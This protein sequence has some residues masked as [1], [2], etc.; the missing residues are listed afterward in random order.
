MTSHLREPVIG[1]GALHWVQQE[2]P[3]EVNA[4]R[5]AFLKKGLPT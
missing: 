5:L 3:A 2:R 1:P 4:A